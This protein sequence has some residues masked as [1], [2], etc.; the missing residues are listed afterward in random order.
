M[1]SDKTV[2]DS[3]RS[4]KNFESFLKKK[5]L[6]YFSDAGPRLSVFASQSVGMFRA[7]SEIVES[8]LIYRNPP[9]A[10]EYSEGR[11]MRQA[12]SLARFL[13]KREIRVNRLREVIP[14]YD[15]VH[16]RGPLATYMAIKSL[17]KSERKLTKII[18][19]CRGL[20]SEEL[21]ISLGKVIFQPTKMIRF[22]EQTKIDKYAVENCDIL[23]TVSEEMSRYYKRKF[24]RLANLVV[25][26][27]VDENSFKFSPQARDEKR[28][29]LGIGDGRLFLYVGGVDK[30]QRLDILGE[31]WKHHS[32]LN[33]ADRLIILTRHKELFLE[34][35]DIPDKSMADK[36]I[37]DFV[38][39]DKVPDYMFASDFGIMFRDDSIVNRAASPVKLSEYLASGLPVITNC[40][41]M[42]DR[43]SRLIYKLD[44]DYNFPD[45]L[46]VLD[47]SQRLSLS[48]A[49]SHE[50][51]GRNAVNLIKQLLIK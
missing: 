10:E 3:D 28:N 34:E 30:W 45:G 25:P 24:G 9:G 15:I 37:F 33:R 17:S 39:Y 11:A 1:E 8:D 35:L 12:G 13:L 51:S 27:I 31:F 4:Q 46:N 6:L 50:L 16:C 32:H 20:I 5:K 42:V 38:T 40:D 43:D 19:D 41:Y 7:W 14:R 44:D 49:N 18:F 22:L 26:T 21:G 2:V 23:L 29:E 36:I 48:L 47:D